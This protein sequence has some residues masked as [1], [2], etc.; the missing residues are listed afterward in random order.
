MGWS[1][2]SHIYF[3]LAILCPVLKNFLHITMNDWG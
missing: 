1:T 3:K 2:F